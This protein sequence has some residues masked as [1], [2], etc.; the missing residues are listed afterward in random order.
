MYLQHGC[1]HAFIS[2]IFIIHCVCHFLCMAHGLFATGPL[3]ASSHVASL[4]ASINVVRR[5]AWHSGNA[6]RW[7]SNIWHAHNAADGVASSDDILTGAL[8]TL[9]GSCRCRAA[10]T[11]QTTRGA[12]TLTGRTPFAALVVHRDG[13]RRYSRILFGIAPCRNSA[14]HNQ[15]TEPL[16]AWRHPAAGYCRLFTRARALMPRV[17]VDLSR[18]IP[19]YAHVRMF[20]VQP[21]NDALLDLRLALS[22]LGGNNCAGS[23]TCLS[24]SCCRDAALR[25]V[26]ARGHAGASRLDIS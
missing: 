2:V 11:I 7:N 16:A 25:R 22:R 13:P 6:R 20:G 15:Q 26:N 17:F 24:P 5:N 8:S 23:Q 14:V 18:R 19:W 9:P 1:A 12:G 3:V 4:L 10:Y 21:R